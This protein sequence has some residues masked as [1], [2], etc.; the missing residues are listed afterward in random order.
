MEANVQKLLDEYHVRAKAEFAAMEK[1]SREEM[2][3]RID[4]FLIP[5]GPDTGALL[6]SLTRSLD[7][8]RVVEIGASYGYSAIWLADAVRQT[9]G[10]V[11]SFELST[12]KIEYATA[13]LRSVGLHDFVEF[14]AG[15][16]LEL[17]QQFDGP[18]DLVLID[19]WKKLYE[20]CF[21]LIYPKVAPQGVVV[22]DNMLFP[23]ETRPLALS[24]QKLVRT[25][26]DLESV[27]LP[28]GSGID[29][30]RRRSAASW[31]A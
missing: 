26:R 28:I 4:E 30:S 17:L 13:K 31:T 27:L 15:D 19:C 6:H 1:L 14:H 9:G 10:K 8:K 23:V 11:H 3:R 24:Y 20:P 29:V 12:S 5:V 25:K 21:E 16:A 2:D 22:A 7:A 18:Y